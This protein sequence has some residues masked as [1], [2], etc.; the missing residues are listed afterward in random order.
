MMIKTLMM[1]EDV[2]YDIPD[3]WALHDLTLDDWSSG[4]RVFTATFVVEET[5]ETEQ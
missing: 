4:K 5:E 2:D 1:N 3:N